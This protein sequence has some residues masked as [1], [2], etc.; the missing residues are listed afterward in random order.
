[1]RSFPE[2]P[3]TVFLDTVFLIYEYEGSAVIYGILYLAPTR[4][5]VPLSTFTIT[6]LPIVEVV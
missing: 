4:V 1:M 5:I 3:F 2:V 6:L